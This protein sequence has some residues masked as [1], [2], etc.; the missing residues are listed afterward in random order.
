MTNAQCCNGKDGRYKCYE[1]KDSMLCAAAPGK[2]AC[3][4]D[5]GG[6]LTTK[7]GENHVLIGVVSWGYGCAEK[8]YPGVYART[9]SQL[10]WIEKTLL[11]TPKL[12][13]QIWR[14]KSVRSQVELTMAECSNRV[15]LKL[16][17]KHSQSVKI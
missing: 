15:N 3:Q 6:P 11:P 16:Y 14:A 8:Y 9:E 2:D 7:Q 13:T 17:Y 10:D 4:G 12:P 5:S 1:L